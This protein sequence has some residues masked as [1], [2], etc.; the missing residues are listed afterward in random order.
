L[1]P[2][3]PGFLAFLLGFLP[4]VA[5][6]PVAPVRAQVLLSTP[7]PTAAE[8]DSLRSRYRRSSR[9][10]QAALY[11]A[12]ALAAQNTIEARSIASHVL[13]EA[14]AAHPRS[15][16]L[17][18]ALADLQY[19]KGYLSLSRREL[20]A[21]LAADSASAPA[22]ARLGRLAF[23][24]WLKF[25]RPEGLAVAK[26]YWD[27]ASRTDPNDTEAWLGLGILALLDND[28][29][30][31][32]KSAR[33]C[34]EAAERTSASGHPAHPGLFGTGPSGATPER[35][36]AAPDP[37]G[38]GWLLL[39]A[40]AYLEGKLDLADSSFTSSLR[41][42][43]RGAR[44]RLLDI[45][46]AASDADTEAWGLRR[47]DSGSEAEFLR[48]FWRSRDPD[49]ITP[50]NEL[51]LEFLMRGAVAY[52]LFFDQRK[53][54]WDERGA[55]LVRYGM[56]EEMVYNPIELGFGPATTNRL[57]WRYHSLGMDV[58]LED[59]YLNETY[60]LPITFTHPAD[61][62]PDA[63]V[64]SA[65]IRNGE[66]T[67]AGRGFFHPAHLG[68]HPLP[69]QAEIAVFRRVRSFDPTGGVSRGREAGRAE[70]YLAVTGSFVGGSPAAEAVV[71]D[72]SWN[73]V[74]RGQAIRPGFCGSDTVQLFQMNFDLPEGD[75][76]VGVAARDP[77]RQAYS[78][79]R[80]PVRVSRPAAGQ[81]EMSDLELVC[82]YDPELRGGPFDKTAFTVLPDPLHAIE[83]GSPLGVYFEIY[84]LTPD[85]NGRSLVS[86]EYTVT[87][88]RPDKRP[89]FVRWVDPRKAQPKVQV[90]REDEVPGRIR[91]QYV[92]ADLSANEPGPYRLDVRVEDRRT[93]YIVKKAA[94][95]RIAP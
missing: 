32:E 71:L 75:Y 38:E 25:Q 70:V 83:R 68:L 47:H 89:F 91:F 85:E 31:A 3:L 4:I 73:E 39:G 80:L 54:T 69:G 35:A 9:D 79:W 14:L 40:A 90:L 7:R 52:F 21:A 76:T 17:H 24:D 66:L 1:R 30:L 26:H 49:L 93:G 44:A 87:S 92:T 23:R 28:A 10:V 94:D 8:V 60:D 82:S 72:S 77:G 58:I 43:S 62:E 27:A 42:L 61:P 46:A 37:R 20:K 41:L 29:P 6:G 55:T 65:A 57:L 78:S 50:V 2:A 88:I 84:G 56:P 19:R 5:L 81:L 33:R 15:S 16:E 45:W 74:A 59:R 48:R 64:V 51:R 86:V 63:A 34:L 53:Q 18:L 13:E 12:R 36:L 22:Y 95:F 67:A 11:Y